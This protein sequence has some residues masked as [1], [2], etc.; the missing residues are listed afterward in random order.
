MRCDPLFKNGGRVTVNLLGYAH[1]KSLINPSI[2]IDVP[3]GFEPDVYAV[4]RMGSVS[5]RTRAVR[6]R[7]GTWDDP[8]TDPLPM[9]FGLR[10]SSDVIDLELWSQGGGLAYEDKLIMRT[11]TVVPACSFATDVTFGPHYE[12]TWLPLAVDS[13]GVA[14]PYQQCFKGN[15]I[16][17]N[18]RQLNAS[19]INV[20]IVMQCHN[21]THVR[22]PESWNASF[23]MAAP[24]SIEQSYF[25]GVNSLN[26]DNWGSRTVSLDSSWPAFLP[27]LGGMIIRFAYMGAVVSDAESEDGY[28]VFKLNFRSTAY[29][30]R[31]FTTSEEFALTEPSWLDSASA[32]ATGSWRLS[33]VTA[34]GI[35]AFGQAVYYRAYTWSMKSGTT[36]TI[37]SMTQGWQTGFNGSIPRLP[38][39]APFLVFKLVTDSTPPDKT[40]SK[41]YDSLPFLYTLFIFLLPQI[42]LVVIL[43]PFGAAIRFRLDLLSPWILSRSL[44]DSDA[45]VRLATER[46]AARLKAKKIKAEKLKAAALAKERELAA[47]PGGASTPNS[48]FFTP[49]SPDETS[50][51]SGRRASVSSIGSRASSDGDKAAE[52]LDAAILKSAATKSNQRKFGVQTID[53]VDTAALIAS[54][55]L[56]HPD[57]IRAANAKRR[58]LQR[59][60]EKF[61]KDGAVAGQTVASLADVITL[62]L[63]MRV[64]GGL[65]ASG[66]L[67]AFLRNG[68]WLVALAYA[69]IATPPLLNNAHGAIL[70]LTTTPPTFGLAV[71]LLGNAFY[72]LLAAGGQWAY[73]GYRP[74]PSTVKMAAAAF[75]LVFVFLVTSCLLDTEVR[76]ISLKALA[77]ITALASFAP[78]V[79]Q[80][81][82]GSEELRGGLQNISD[83]VRGVAAEDR[84]RSAVA[85]RRAE[86][87]TASRIRGFHESPYVVEAANAEIKTA[88]QTA[89]SVKDGSIGVDIGSTL[90]LGLGGEPAVGAAMASAVYA[91]IEGADF[92]R[93]EVIEA[94][95]AS[96]EARA[97]KPTIVDW[98]GVNPD[99]SRRVIA[100]QATVEPEESA[101]PTSSRSLSVPAE[102]AAA[103]AAAA[104]AASAAL[105]DEQLA[106]RTTLGLRETEDTAMRCAAVASMPWQNENRGDSIP[107]SIPKNS[108]SFSI[109]SLL[110][111][112]LFTLSVASVSPEIGFLDGFAGLLADHSSII[113]R[114]VRIC[115]AFSFFVYVLHV[116]AIF[117][118]FGLRLGLESLPFV[119]A[120]YLSDET[121]NSLV[122]AG[123]MNQPPIMF[124]VV[125]AA[126]RAFLVAHVENSEWFTGISLAY[127]CMALPLGLDA[128]INCL[129]AIPIEGAQYAVLLARFDMAGEF[130]RAVKRAHAN[131]A[132]W[133]DDWVRMW[134]IQL[135]RPYGIHILEKRLDLNQVPPDNQ[136]ELAAG[137]IANALGTRDLLG[138]GGTSELKKKL[139]AQAM[140]LATDDE[141]AIEQARVA[142]EQEAATIAEASKKAKQ[143]RDLFQHNL[144]KVTKGRVKMRDRE[145]ALLDM[146]RQK[147]G[148]AADKLDDGYLADVSL[149]VRMRRVEGAKGSS[150]SSTDRAAAPAKSSSGAFFT[151][152]ES[153]PA[154]MMLTLIYVPSL[155]AVYIFQTYWEAVGRAI[156]YVE[157]G[158]FDQVTEYPQS[159]S[160]FWGVDGVTSSIVGLSAIASVWIPTLFCAA[161]ISFLNR[162][163]RMLTHRS[164]VLVPILQNCRRPKKKPGAQYNLSMK[165]LYEVQYLRLPYPIYLSGLAWVASIG[166]MTS[167]M[168]LAAANS[169]NRMWSLPIAGFFGPPILAEVV[170]LSLTFVQNGYSI[171][172]PGHMRPTLKRT[173]IVITNNRAGHPLSKTGLLEA[174]RRGLT[175][176]EQKMLKPLEFGRNLDEPSLFTRPCIRGEYDKDFYDSEAAQ[177]VAIAAENKAAAEQAQGDS[178]VDEMSRADLMAV[179]NLRELAISKGITPDS[180]EKKGRSCFYYLF[181]LCCCANCPSTATICASLCNYGY[182]HFQAEKLRYIDMSRLSPLGA[183][184]FGKLAPSDYLTVVRMRSLL[185]LIIAFAVVLYAMP[186]VPNLVFAIAV[187]VVPIVTLLS[188]SSAIMYVN[189]LRV[190]PEIVLFTASA[191][192]LNV[193]ALFVILAQY[194]SPADV[195]DSRAAIAVAVVFSYW[196]ALA[197]ITGMSAFFERKMKH[198]SMTAALVIF[199]VL[200]ALIL[201]LILFVF[202]PY[203]TLGAGT[204]AGAI[205]YTLAL[206]LIHVRAHNGGVVPGGIWRAA[207]QFVV[208]LALFPLVIL[209]LNSMRPVATITFVYAASWA[210]II[211]GAYSAGRAIARLWELASSVDGYLSFGPAVMPLFSFNPETAL[212]VC[213][214]DIVYD[215][216]FAW[217]AVFA[218]GVVLVLFADP[219]WFGIALMSASLAVLVV[220]VLQ[221]GLHPVLTLGTRSRFLDADAVTGA[222]S[223]A[224][225]TFFS[226]R[227]I[228]PVRA[229]LPSNVTSS[230]SSVDYFANTAVANSYEQRL[231]E[232]AAL[233][234][235]ASRT[236]RGGKPTKSAIAARARLSAMASIDPGREKQMA[237]LDRELS[238]VDASLR[239]SEWRAGISRLS[240]ASALDRLQLAKWAMEKAWPW[241]IPDGLTSREVTSEIVSRLNVASELLETPA[242]VVRASLADILPLMPPALAAKTLNDALSKLCLPK[243][244]ALIA[245]LE[246]SA[247]PTDVVTLARAL[248][249]NSFV[250]PAIKKGSSAAFFL[251]N[252]TVAHGPAQY[253]VVDPKS[254][255]TGFLQMELSKS[256]RDA[257]AALEL[258]ALKE[259][260]EKKARLL[261]G[262]GSQNIAAVAPEKAE[263][264]QTADTEGSPHTAPPHSGSKKSRQHSRLPRNERSAASAAAPPERSKRAI[265]IDAIAAPKRR[266]KST[267][268]SMFNSL[269]RVSDDAPPVRTPSGLIVPSATALSAALPAGSPE[270]KPSQP[271]F[272]P[273]HLYRLVSSSRS[274]L[275]SLNIQDDDDDDAILEPGQGGAESAEAA[276]HPLNLYSPPKRAVRKT[277]KV[278]VPHSNYSLDVEKDTS[279]VLVGGRRSNNDMATLPSQRKQAELVFK[280]PLKSRFEFIRHFFRFIFRPLQ[281]V[282]E[283]FIMTPPESVPVTKAPSWFRAVSNAVKECDDTAPNAASRYAERY[284]KTAQTRAGGKPLPHRLADPVRPSGMRLMPSP[285]AEFERLTAQR[286]ILFEA[287]RSHRNFSETSAMAACVTHPLYQPLPRPDRPWSFGDAI[288]DEVIFASGPFK[289]I[290]G[291]ACCAARLRAAATADKCVR[292]VLC[293]SRAAKNGE[294][295][296]RSAPTAD[297]T[298]GWCCRR[299]PLFSQETLASLLSIDASVASVVDADISGAA[300]AAP[301]AVS[302]VL[303]PQSAGKKAPGKC[304]LC[305]YRVGWALF[306][307]ADFALSASIGFSPQLWYNYIYGLDEATILRAR[308][309]VTES[310]EAVMNPPEK[311]PA[312][313]PLTRS[314]AV[315]VAPDGS[316]DYK[317][318]LDLH[319][320]GKPS[321]NSLFA[322]LTRGVIAKTPAKEGEPGALANCDSHFSKVLHAAS[323]GGEAEHDATVRAAHRL[324]PRKSRRDLA[325][326]PDIPADAQSQ[327]ADPPASLPYVCR[328]AIDAATALGVEYYEE[329]RAMLHAQLVLCAYGDARRDVQIARFPTAFGL[330]RKAFADQGIPV[331]AMDV[332]GIGSDIS[333]TAEWLS[334]QPL[335]VQDLYADLDDLFE[336]AEAKERLAL[337]RDYVESTLQKGDK[338]R[339]LAPHFS[340][341]RE[342]FSKLAAEA[343]GIIFESRSALRISLGICTPQADVNKIAQEIAVEAA[344]AAAEEGKDDAAAAVKVVAVAAAVAVEPEAAPAEIVN[345]APPPPVLPSSAPGSRATTGASVNDVSA[346]DNA[347]AP[348]DATHI[349]VG[350]SGEEMEIMREA[351][352]AQAMFAKDLEIPEDFRGLQLSKPEIHL[353][354]ISIGQLLVTDIER[355]GKNCSDSVTRYRTRQFVDDSFLPG[356]N[357]IGPLEPPKICRAINSLW[358]PSVAFS[359]NAQIFVGG[360]DPDDVIPGYAFSDQ[361][362]LTAACML[363]SS[364]G[365]GDDTVDPLIDAIFVTKRMP[366]TGVAALR[367]KVDGEKIIVLLDDLFPALADSR[368]TPRKEWGK[369]TP[370]CAGAAGSHSANFSETWVSIMEKAMAKI[371]GNFAELSDGFIEHALETFTCSE[372]SRVPIQLFATGPLRSRFF[373]DLYRWVEVCGFLVAAQSVSSTYVRPGAPD[374]SANEGQHAKAAKPVAPATALA[375]DAAVPTSAAAPPRPNPPSSKSKKR[376]VNSGYTLSPSGI[377]EGAFYV[378]HAVANVCGQ[379]LVRIREPPGIVSQFKGPF[380]TGSSSWTP[381]LASELDYS[382]DRDAKECAFWMTFDDFVLNFCV[383]FVCR[384]LPST[385]GKQN[386]KK[387][388]FTV[389]TAG[390]WLQSTSTAG[391]LV[392]PASEQHPAIQC[393]PAV[394]DH[395]DG[396][397]DV[398]R[399]LIAVSHRHRHRR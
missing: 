77:T 367:C 294:V 33:N 373:R 358:R 236:H 297:E 320:I 261:S 346:S 338:E 232:R 100:P 212:P 269:F 109:S 332:T 291:F 76:G 155:I 296:G 303:P 27:A 241:A 84:A 306:D 364:G 151:L 209:G 313:F 157:S 52:E 347:A 32:K 187:L 43:L 387:K 193:F 362:L 268:R 271:E 231:R 70:L 146:S 378:V 25:T 202:G 169:K 93:R 370:Y 34:R 168:F 82:L 345:I 244:R 283:L 19:C 341:I 58:A 217:C 142:A 199:S 390:A 386:C 264:D 277:T 69:L 342:N 173:D 83:M 132:H 6:A 184:L 97:T 31:E 137:V 73:A 12:R 287:L 219:V 103:S 13:S 54:A 208:I 178:N 148:G 122:Q 133:Q 191:L 125:S 164:D 115:R 357:A 38:S 398:G 35:N 49:K 165:I 144:T 321:A 135:Q 89:F 130:S 213:E 230:C 20:Q 189:T 384:V 41:T 381:R 229:M 254:R 172:A 55:L 85:A 279:A 108:V 240:A 39:V 298:I 114:T 65:V 75:A 222:R 285:A 259:A 171:A 340:S 5:Y 4:A 80:L 205:M 14:L 392:A 311:D 23:S 399:D 329:L 334:L 397:N 48:E 86:D 251:E 337:N 112:K 131:A 71:L 365:V 182:R 266:E 179:K 260:A 377:A 336:D 92:E 224:I 196:G 211:F 203:L 339:R 47:S 226:R 204:F 335:H 368:E 218:W 389:D 153:W 186:A 147:L 328:E 305:C 256:A 201:T 101:A 192:I 111:P 1:A 326:D 360:T 200:A 96:R 391:G 42:C 67:T 237:M 308:K 154:L 288:T 221:V 156:P 163:R 350:P 56:E 376:G 166:L 68:S 289:Y 129:P 152:S 119:F 318:S 248:C 372:T 140:V 281:I 29:L 149:P 145:R 104:S 314:G 106:A 293:G 158:L 393:N 143:L 94:D 120:L 206:A 383:L 352:D 126:V 91:L 375:P 64:K 238:F 107:V 176:V 316:V 63:I 61:Q 30:F 53:L 245:K 87:E 16:L 315:A 162:K 353:D 188:I 139:A 128:T 309:L 348:E 105:V 267:M 343:R 274:Q 210:C 369:V 228:I 121:L 354:E 45:S 278:H 40:P 60:V 195:R 79:L 127:A 250:V 116:V 302:A 118:L 290:I 11:Q 26:A 220:A 307:M 10:S 257:A 9:F 284:H 243:T 252:L 72:L 371:Y 361:W 170:L 233:E 394:G 317:R 90:G 385:V 180:I 88:K 225:D 262:N 161:A 113:A 177:S 78:I 282:Y 3:T 295:V 134:R 253:G 136:Q 98:G 374:D 99:G 359:R 275:Q 181:C 382:Q 216:A 292:R 190:T 333:A 50:D 159:M 324:S 174:W 197:G 310:A 265:S 7:S 175:M 300:D 223:I 280:R 37:K 351:A 117:N 57:T 185:L 24:I 22:V 160:R 17:G 263:E 8:D 272:L 330:S 207:L 15:R 379:R 331:P 44:P 110:G 327:R 247:N 62:P 323:T 235:S 66:A 183:F 349:E 312:N 301:I 46:A 150:G 74:T 344:R 242:T 239:L 388:W 227:R 366:S 102:S 273:E 322:V 198:T 234:A 28:A 299:L 355:N 286:A 194:Y 356:P 380:C 319:S 138:A 2:P 214:N 18:E 81:F 325:A 270:C 396:R 246:C 36:F 258:V 141:K 255:A 59:D 215:M 21:V 304:R 123:L 395:C 95:R 276:A 124:A 363:S 167:L 51:L 249:S